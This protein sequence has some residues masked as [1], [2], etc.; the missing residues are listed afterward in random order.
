MKCFF[1]AAEKLLGARFSSAGECIFFS[2]SSP[3]WRRYISFMSKQY[4]FVDYFLNSHYLTTWQLMNIER[5]IT[6]RSPVEIYLRIWNVF[7]NAFFILSD[8]EAR[9]LSM[10]RQLTGTSWRLQWG[11]QA[12]VTA[13]FRCL[14]SS[15][16]FIS[17]ILSVSIAQISK[18]QEEPRTLLETFNT[19]KDTEDKKELYLNLDYAFFKQ[20]RHWKKTTLVYPIKITWAFY[21]Q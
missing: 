1:L 7:Q 2:E 3:Y 20:R 21:Y 17:L 14:Y 11:F 15:F 18:T 16:N 12:D 6:F 9:S 8:S 4:P 13:L 10:T 19:R 5:E